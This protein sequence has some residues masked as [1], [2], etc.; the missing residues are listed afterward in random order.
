MT[1]AVIDRHKALCERFPGLKEFFLEIDRREDEISGIRA[2]IGECFDS[3]WADLLVS[4]V[5]PLEI[6]HEMDSKEAIV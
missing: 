4:D 6:V 1:D 3:Y 5:L 2:E